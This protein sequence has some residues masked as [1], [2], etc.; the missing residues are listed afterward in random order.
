MPPPTHTGCKSQY[1]FTAIAGSI[2]QYQGMQQGF[3]FD[4][5]TMTPR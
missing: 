2:L 3:L 1:L 5:A 4:P